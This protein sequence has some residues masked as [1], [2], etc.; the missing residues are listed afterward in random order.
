[1]SECACLQSTYEFSIY[2]RVKHKTV[3]GR[4]FGSN[5][6]SWPK[7]TKIITVNGKTIE[8]LETRRDDIK[9]QLEIKYPTDKYYIRVWIK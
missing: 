4:F 9:N 8:E 1:M 7:V 3:I 5:T 6:E 2:K